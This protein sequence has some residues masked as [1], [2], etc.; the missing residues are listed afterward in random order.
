MKFSETEIGKKLFEE[1]YCRRGTTAEQDITDAINQAF[2]EGYNQIICTYH[3]KTFSRQCPC[4]L[5]GRKETEC[6]CLE[7][8][9]EGL[10][11][12]RARLKVEVEKMLVEWESSSSLYDAHKYRIEI[13]IKL[14]KVFK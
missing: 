2:E 8:F 10:L 3:G 7:N 4:F 9:D 12:E 14:A 13:A 1:F 11:K 6:K 5:E